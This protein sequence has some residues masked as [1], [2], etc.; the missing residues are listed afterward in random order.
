MGFAFVES[1]GEMLVYGGESRQG[2]VL[3]DTWTFDPGPPDVTY[4]CIGAPNSVG[5]G[6]RIGYYG[7][8]SIAANDFH[9][10]VAHAPPHQ[11]GLFFYGPGQDEVLFGNGYRCIAPYPTGLFR[12]G[13]P[14]PTDVAGTVIRHVDFDLLSGGDGEIFPGSTWNFQFWY[15]DPA[16]GGE[17]FNLSDALSAIFK[18]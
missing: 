7:S 13:P 2:T 1:S 18:L 8:T 11:F 17:Q 3:G 6:A 4:Y 10:T 14:L 16:H 9:L 12:L 15:R 5:S